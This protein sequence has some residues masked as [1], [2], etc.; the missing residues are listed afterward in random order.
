V[1]VKNNIVLA[2]MKNFELYTDHMSGFMVLDK[3][4]SHVNTSLNR[5]PCLKDVCWRG[6]QAESQDFTRGQGTDFNLVGTSSTIVICDSLRESSIC[7]IGQ[8][9]SPAG[10]ISI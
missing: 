5:T 1:S 4:S 2:P 7:R 6:I 3:R 8:V 9:L 10:C